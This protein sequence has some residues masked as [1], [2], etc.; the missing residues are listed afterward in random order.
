MPLK[1]CLFGASPDTSNMGVSALCYSVV[2]GILHHAPDAEITVFDHGRGVRH[3]Q[4]AQN[5]TTRGITRCGAN[6]T[7]RLWR[8]ESFFQIRLARRFGLPN[9]AAR[10]I[11][12]ADAVLDISGGDSF[13]DLYGPQRFATVAATKRM[14]LDAGRPLVLLPQ[15]YGPYNDPAN[16]REA[17][18][19]VRA[20]TM[21]WARDERSFATLKELLGD[22][23]DPARH[24]SGVDVAFAL[25]TREPAT[26]L[27]EPIATWL[28]DQ[29]ERPT[30]GFNVSGLIYN[31]PVA[32]RERYHFKADYRE[33]VHGFLR[34]VL[35][36]TDANVVLIP[37]VYAYPGAMES[38]PDACAAVLRALRADDDGLVAAAAAT[39]LAAVQPLGEDPAQVKWVISRCDWFC[40]TRM[41]ATIAGLS[42]G[43]PTAAIAYSLKTQ[44]VFETCGVG[45]AVV[46]PRELD[47]DAVVAGLFDLWQRRADLRQ[48]LATGVAPVRQQAVD[49]LAAVVAA[50]R[51]ELAVPGPTTATPAS[52]SA[53]HEEGNPTA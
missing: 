2:N 34:H 51:D 38:D 35:A 47:T 18:S 15:T 1:F 4:V 39:R 41:H 3:E 19:L 42:T 22:A 11:R 9:A 27:P 37:H 50:A 29:R 46:D 32:M 30:I 13:T 28:G 31:D 49:E 44:G 36:E 53:R 17:A 6:Q 48:R 52:A 23:F 14:A 12:E 20:A 33:V 43:V 25:P 21:C 10:A 8:P 24:R 16:R 5:G 45:D 26:P 40:G 7:R